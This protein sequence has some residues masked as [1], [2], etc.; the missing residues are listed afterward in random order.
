MAADILVQ[1][2]DFLVQ[3]YEF[4]LPILVIADI[5]FAITIIFIERKNPT[6]AV[7]WLLVLLLLPFIGFF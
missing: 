6:R 5:F 2:F 4:L 7:S 3:L 1:I